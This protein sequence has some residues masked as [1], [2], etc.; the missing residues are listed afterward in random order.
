MPKQAT[1][2]A[3]LDTLAVKRTTI[4]DNKTADNKANVNQL[5]GRVKDLEATVLL[6]C[7]LVIVLTN[8][9]KDDPTAV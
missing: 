9:A 3:M 7:R 1:Y 6:L 2:D 5:A 8:P 4:K